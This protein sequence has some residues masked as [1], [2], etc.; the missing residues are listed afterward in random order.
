[1]AGE[2]RQAPTR[3]GSEDRAVREFRAAHTIRSW[4]TE[5]DRSGSTST[6]RGR[7]DTA[8]RRGDGWQADSAG[9]TSGRSQARRQVRSPGDS[10]QGARGSAAA[11]R[12]GKGAKVN[13]TRRDRVVAIPACARPPP[14]EP[15][16]PHPADALARAA[17]LRCRQRGRR[18]RL[19][20]EPGRPR[21]A[22]RPRR[23]LA[24]RHLDRPP[25]PGPAGRAGQDRAPEYRRGALSARR[26]SQAA[27]RD[28]RVGHLELRQLRRRRPEHGQRPLAPARLRPQPVDRPAD[29]RVPQGTWPVRRSRTVV[30]GRGHRSGDVHP[31]SGVSQDPRRRASARP[32]LDPS[33]ELPGRHQA[34]GEVRVQSGRGARQGSPA[35]AQRKAGP[36]RSRRAGARAGSRR[37]HPPRHHRSPRSSRSRP[38]RRPA[39]ADLQEGD[40]EDRRFDA[41]AW[42]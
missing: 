9:R 20:D 8:G 34:A 14:P 1:M 23:D 35:R 21:R 36:G 31:G 16:R 4:P 2:P 26:Q 6:G 19:L 42:S 41:R 33:R 37:V 40:F 30:E 11:P 7:R 10:R 3:S 32:E 15:P 27:Q 29:C 22:S 38:A 18:Q 12:P 17:R 13:R 39:Q 5:P 25:A 28:A 24:Q